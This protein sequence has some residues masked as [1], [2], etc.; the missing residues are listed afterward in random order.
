MNATKVLLLT[1]LGA[2]YLCAQLPAPVPVIGWSGADPGDGAA[3]VM[4]PISAYSFAEAP[5][6]TLVYG[7]SG[8][9]RKIDG[10]GKIRTLISDPTLN[11]TS[12]AFDP[13]GNLYYTMVAPEYQIRRF[14]GGNSVLVA[15]GGTILAADGVTQP[16][17]F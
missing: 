13:A 6:G 12:L 3:A 7:E 17:P 9:I 14:S 2:K 15:G 4:T 10:S 16:T 11:G 1:V 5:D 8:R